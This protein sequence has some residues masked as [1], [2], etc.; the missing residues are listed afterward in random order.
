MYVAEDSTQE[1]ATLLHNESKLS[2]PE[3]ISLIFRSG[4]AQISNPFFPI[5]SR[6]SLTVTGQTA[7][8]QIIKR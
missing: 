2:S 3:Q 8:Q 7:K 4:A 1:T 6:A 5:H